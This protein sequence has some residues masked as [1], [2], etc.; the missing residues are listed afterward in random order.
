MEQDYGI[1]TRGCTCLSVCAGLHIKTH[2]PFNEL[3]PLGS[4]QLPLQTGIPE[5]LLLQSVAL[6]L[7]DCFQMLLKG[8]EV[9]P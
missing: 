3:K 9:T 1:V 6:E 5:A 8:F 7:E 4:V 2:F